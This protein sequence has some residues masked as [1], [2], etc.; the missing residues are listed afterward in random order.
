MV[1]SV[2]PKVPTASTSTT[3]A[4]TATTDGPGRRRWL[5]LGVL[6]A[7]LS[8]IVI[9]G[10]IVGI[11]LPR[12]IDDRGLSLA[13]AQWVTSLYSVVFAALLLTAGRVADRIGR[14]KLFVIG[15]VVF[16]LGSVIAAASLDATSLIGARVVQGIGGAIVLPT[17]L[18]TVN[19]TFRGKDR[20][21][22]FG[23]WG[24]V[25]SGSAAIGPLLGGW[26]TGSFG[27]QWI[28]I[29]N[30]P[31][32]A[33]ILVGTFLTVPETKSAIAE[34]GFD[35]IGLVLSAVGFGS[36]VFAVIEGPSLGW[37]TPTASGTE[38][39]AWWPDT[40]AISPVPVVLATAAAALVAF[41]FWERKR[42]AAGRTVLLDLALFRTATFSW[43]NV[44]AMMVAIGEFGLLFVLPLF[45]MNTHGLSPLVAGLILATM[46]AGAF[47][48]GASARHLAAKLGA[49]RVVVVGLALEAVG[50]VLLAT[51]LTDTLSPWFIVGVLIVYGLGLGLASAQLTGTTLGDI[52]ADLSGQGSATQSTVRQVGAALGT[53]I[54]GAVIALSLGSH[55]DLDSLTTGATRL[56]LAITAVFL[57]LGLLAAFRVA[58]ASRRT[59]TALPAD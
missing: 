16:V 12:I 48:A 42:A 6:A 1:E 17:T 24:A 56:T 49:P 59:A 13:E 26:L 40:A 43:G 34:R 29:V 47:V 20:A 25:I 53:A 14:R 31:L 27:W 44:T 22:A 52:P 33:L 45:L 4:A 8:L 41:V 15:V 28:F 35:V 30:V 51:V 9:D 39:I 7:G 38:S 55:A 19:A 50:V 36:L 5:G 23:I 18:S 46:A 3:G 57:V 32:G 21:A 11:A 10:T 54:A 58:A 37:F 2:T